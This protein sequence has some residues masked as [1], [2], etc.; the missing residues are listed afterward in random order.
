MKGIKYIDFQKSVSDKVA[1]FHFIPALP[2][3]DQ[4]TLGK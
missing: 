4:V 1:Y 3:I 2:F